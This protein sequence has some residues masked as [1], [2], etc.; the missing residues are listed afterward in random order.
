MN[1]L[2]RTLTDRSFWRSIRMAVIVLVPLG[3]L[4]NITSEFVKQDDWV[5]VGF[6]LAAVVCQMLL[7]F[8]L[9]PV[10]V[11]RRQRQ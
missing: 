3:V 1:A 5:H 7:Y 9:W 4:G 6:C 11:R 10:V 2:K 8:T